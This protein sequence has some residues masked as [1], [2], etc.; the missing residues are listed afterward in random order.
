MKCCTWRWS[1][2]E[3]GTTT[4]YRNGKPYGKPYRKGAATFP[5]NRTSVIFGL[6]HLPP[7]GNK[8]L[9]VSLDKA[10]LYDRALTAEEVASSYSGHRSLHLRRGIGRRP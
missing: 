8:F 6:R 5:K 4:L 7:G 9:A 1:T 2:Q 3:D 10:R